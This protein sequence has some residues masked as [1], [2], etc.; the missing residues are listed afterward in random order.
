MTDV[1]AGAESVNE[2]VRRTR[3]ATVAAA[4]TPPPVAVTAAPTVTPC[5]EGQT[6][7]AEA[8]VSS[9]RFG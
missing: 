2:L 9:V 4:G 8:L 7:A 1:V 5:S 6:T 3:A